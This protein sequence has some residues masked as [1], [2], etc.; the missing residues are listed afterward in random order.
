MLDDTS[1]VGNWVLLGDAA[2][3]SEEGMPLPAVE[4]RLGVP[5]METPQR[6]LVIV[7]VPGVEG[8]T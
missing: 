8:A 3:I 2:A 6:G 1:I 7:G 4:G 5:S